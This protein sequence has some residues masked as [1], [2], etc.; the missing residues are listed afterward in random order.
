MSKRKSAT[1]ATGKRK[2]D[3]APRTCSAAT[4]WHELPKAEQDKIVETSGMKMGQFLKRYKQPDWCEYP[5]ALAGQ[6]G[7]WSL[8]LSRSIHGIKDCGKCDC[9]KKVKQPN[10]KLRH[11][12]P[13]ETEGMKP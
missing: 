9:I 1:V 7:C 13:A 12:A 5:E 6:M 10:E 3:C 2:P 11:S 8:I 4:Y